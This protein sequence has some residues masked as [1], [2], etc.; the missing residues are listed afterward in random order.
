MA[1]RLTPEGEVAESIE[2]IPG[3]TGFINPLDV[4]QDPRT[5][6]LYVSDYGAQGL[7][8]VRPVAERGSSAAGEGLE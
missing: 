1:I 3:F 7:V 8:L 5:G 4:T 2:G 6:Y